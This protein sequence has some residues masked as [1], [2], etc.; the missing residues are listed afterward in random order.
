MFRKI[1]VDGSINKFEAILWKNGREKIGL[2]DSDFFQEF[3]YKFND[4]SSFI[5]NIPNKISRNGRTIDNHIYNQIKGKRYITINNSER[6]VISDVKIKGNKDGKI[7]NITAKSMEYELSKR[8]I[9]INGSTM[10]LYKDKDEKV[11]IGDGVLNLLEQSTSWK[12]GYVDELAGNNHGVYPE[13]KA[14]IL[15]TNKEFKNM[16]V[17]T[18]LYDIDVNIDIG[19]IALNFDINYSN[20]ISKDSTN[21]ILKTENIKHS[22]SNFSQGITHIKA[23]YCLGDNYKEAIKYEFTLKDGFVKLVTQEFTFLNNLN[24]LFSSI[25]L[26]YETGKRVEQLKRKYRYFEKGNKKWL[27]FLREDIAKAFNCVFIFDTFNKIINVYSA[28]NYGVEKDLSLSYQNFIQELNIE[29]RSDEVISRLY[30]Q[31]KNNLQINSVNPLGTNYVEDFSYLISQGNMSDSLKSALKR[32]DNL[33]NIIQKEWQDL[34]DK[35]NVLVQKSTFLQS[36]LLEIQEKLKVQEKLRISYMKQEKD[37]SIDTNKEKLENSLVDEK[38]K[39]IAGKITELTNKQNE[40]MKSLNNVNDNIKKINDRVNVLNNNLVMKNSVDM[41]GTIFSKEDLIELDEALI[42]D[43]YQDSFYTTSLGLYTYSKDLLKRKNMLPIKF[44]TTMHNLSKVNGGWKNYIQL[45]QKIRIKDEEVEYSTKD[46]FVRIIGFK[47]IIK[48]KKNKEQVLNIEF[49]NE[50][51][52]VN[53]DPLQAIADI[54]RKSDYSSNMVDYWKETWVDGVT[55]GDFVKNMIDK[56]LNTATSAV[57]SRASVNQVDITETG[58]WCIDRSDD[59]DGNNQIYIGSGMIAITDDKWNTSKLCIDKGG[60][61]ADRLIGKMVFSEK[62][63]ATSE[64]GSFTIT[65]DGMTVYDELGR[66]R[67]KLGVYELNG[68]KKAS[69]LMYSKDGQRIMI[70]EDGIAQVDSQSSVD[71]VDPEHPMYFPVYIQDNIREIRNAILFLH[72]DKYRAYFK[73]TMGGGAITKSS[74]GGGAIT[75]SSE[76]GGGTTTSSSAGGQINT[77]SWGGGGITTSSQAGG[78]Y[79]NSTNGGGEC[80]SGAGGY[81]AKSTGGDGSHRHLMFKVVGGTSSG[82]FTPVYDI[83]KCSNDEGNPYNSVAMPRDNGQSGDLYTYSA[84]GYHTHGFTVPNHTHYVQGHSHWFTVPSHSHTI[85]IPDHTHRVVVEAHTHQITLPNHT[86]QIVLPN[87]THTIVLPNHT[88][89]P[90]YKIVEDTTPTDIEIVINGNSVKK[91]INGD[92][93]INIAQY[94][95]LGQLNIIEISS[96]T[97]G[98]INALLSMS[99]FA[100]F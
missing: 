80:T 87:H 47:H 14:E 5:A 31:G 61:I 95:K 44:T 3:N 33:T 73:G 48:S 93:E 26:D 45:G 10:Q 24:V 94:L 18:V 83:C 68:E 41:N 17:N 11:H 35:K 64:N 50:E 90:I 77:T 82:M 39:E 72:I 92:F 25:A 62:F 37:G 81:T 42:D 43:R 65:G 78:Y 38:L 1:K 97:N 36:V 71:N 23:T 98:R 16:Q 63:I 6:Y 34:Y 58:I 4:V 32:Y 76:A 27:S 69:L 66:E 20:L 52:N 60:I 55:T 56:G 9:T 2:V 79:A 84:N 29:E 91:D 19:E 67:V 96:K 99:S 85:A 40:N 51:I 53:Q 100:S 75:K 12:I 70:S 21:E 46:G 22:F 54:G 57:R 88:H 7:K 15:A 13:T 28:E 59:S 8:D 49:S 74:E 86:H 89:A 30:V